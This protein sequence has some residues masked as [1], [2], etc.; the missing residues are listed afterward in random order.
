MLINVPIRR[1]SRP[2][3][4]RT[5]QTMWPGEKTNANE[6]TTIVRRGWLRR[7]GDDVDPRQ[8]AHFCIF[9]WIHYMILHSRLIISAARCCILNALWFRSFIAL[10]RWASNMNR[11]VFFICCGFPF[12]ARRPCRRTIIQICAVR[13]DPSRFFAL[14]HLSHECGLMSHARPAKVSMQSIWWSDKSRTNT[15]TAIWTGLASGVRYE[16]H[17]TQNAINKNVI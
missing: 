2:T 11:F 4:P 10:D 14:H 8:R 3:R 12:S 15:V 6:E 9:H 5:V 1:R 7:P 16:L 17:V 13:I